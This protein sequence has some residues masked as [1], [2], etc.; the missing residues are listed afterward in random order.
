MTA[1]VE[2]QSAGGQFYTTL[3]LVLMAVIAVVFGIVNNF[4][5][6][7]YQSLQ[8][9]GGPWLAELFAVFSIPA[10][11]AMF[12]IRKPGVALITWLLN[13]A[14]QALAGN[15]AG[16]G[17]LGWGVTSGIAMEVVFAIA[18]YRNFGPIVMFIAAGMS[19]VAG[20]LW[21]Y[22]LFG[23][24]GT[25]ASAPQILIVSEIIAFIATGTESGLVAFGIGTLLKRS[26]L[27][28]SFRVSSSL[29]DSGAAV[30][31]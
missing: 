16:I 31:P 24:W 28:R 27:L 29:S 21:S 14:V 11:L 6:V 12:I 9:A 2:R 22:T 15:P 7:F 23:L 5:G 3:D 1:N 4:F 17:A 13:S 25:V 30:Q 19:E 26:G 10:A 18:G 8:A 20:V